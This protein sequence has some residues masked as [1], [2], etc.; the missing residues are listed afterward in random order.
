MIGT[1]TERLI[2][3]LGKTG[4]SIAAW[5]ADQ[6][7]PF[8]V[9]DTREDPPQAEAVRELCP[10]ERLHFGGWQHDWLAAADE[11]YVS[12]GLALSEPPVREALERGAVLISDIDLYRQ[13]SQARVIAV[14][15]S[16]GKSTVVRLLEAMARDAGSNAL[17]GGNIGIPALE[18]LQKPHDLAV[19][20]LSSFQLEM[21]HA[22]EA[23]VAMV[24]NIS[25]DHQDR[26]ADM[27][28]YRAAKHR[29]F[30]GCRGVVVHADDPLTQP[31]VSE[32]M[33]RREYSL[34]RR[35]IGLL[36]MQATP[37]GIELYQGL[38]V[39]HTWRRLYLKGTHNQL[40]ILAALS[41]GLL[42]GWPLSDMVQTI[43]E[44]RGLPH[45]CAWSGEA[46]GVTF[47]NDSKGTNVGATLAALSGLAPECPGRLHLLAG[48]DGK[49]ADFNPLGRACSEG[50]VH[51]Q[52]YG[53][54]GAAIAAAAERHGLA[55]GR[56]ETL[57]AAF[58]AAHR[59]A[60]PG[61]WVIL[62]PACASF[63]QYA[64]FEARGEAFEALVRS[65]SAPTGE[66]TS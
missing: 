3:G 66:V 37:A 6:G 13:H 35:D 27:N 9:I 14:T 44:F 21:T 40:N 49:D 46:G 39:V 38:E 54:D 32:Q 43:A 29:V 64:G 17:A 60:R 7:R 5:L 16:N 36:S 48:G 2:L 1:D 18:L 23:D 50:A 26:Y 11:L 41:A 63:D 56:H 28:A 8:R 47:I 30:Q 15:G 10:P 20:E 59:N 4:F 22:L 55:A 62:S 61:D 58:E 34:R 45:R 65:L 42:M 24:L 33:P 51:L 31:L 53:R 57:E 19:L 12:P 52:T 25:P